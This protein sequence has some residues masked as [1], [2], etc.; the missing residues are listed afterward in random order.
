[1]VELNEFQSEVIGFVFSGIQFK[2]KLSINGVYPWIELL[3][4]QEDMQKWDP[5]FDYVE[6]ARGI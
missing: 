1:M 2:D 4:E 5:I 6:E 3:G